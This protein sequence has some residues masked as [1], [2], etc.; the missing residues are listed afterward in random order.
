LPLFLALL[1]AWQPA[2]GNDSGIALSINDRYSALSILPAFDDIKSEDR[3]SPTKQRY[4]PINMRQ[5]S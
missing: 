5:A 3:H 1:C 2:N 4:S